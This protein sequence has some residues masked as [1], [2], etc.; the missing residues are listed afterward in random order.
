MRSGN[1]QSHHLRANELLFM[2]NR[3]MQLRWTGLLYA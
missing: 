1:R 2:V 3:V